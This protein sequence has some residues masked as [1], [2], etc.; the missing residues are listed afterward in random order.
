MLYRRW[1]GVIGDT[2]LL[3]N[4]ELYFK[5]IHH[6]KDLSVSKYRKLQVFLKPSK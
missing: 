1:S 3:D 2:I 6:A 5:K 4:E